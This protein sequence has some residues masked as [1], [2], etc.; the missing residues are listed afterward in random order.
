MAVIF[1]KCTWSILLALAF[2]PLVEFWRKVK[3]GLGN[4][5]QLSYLKLLF[6]SYLNLIPTSLSK[7]ILTWS[8]RMYIFYILLFSNVLY[9]AANQIDKFEIR[10]KVR[11][12]KSYYLN[13]CN[14][15]FVSYL[16]PFSHKIHTNIKCMSENVLF[17]CTWP[18]YFDTSGIN[19]LTNWI[20]IW[21]QIVSQDLNLCAV[22]QFLV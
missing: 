2:K 16:W 4:V 17:R 22:E 8:P 5:P 6:I 12:H 20:D 13:I 3:I 7:L 14:F 19:Q 9:I 21:Q 1:H 18:A 10:W 15:K 11:G